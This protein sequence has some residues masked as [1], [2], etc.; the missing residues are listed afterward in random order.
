MRILMIGFL[1]A[2]CGGDKGDSGGAADVATPPNVEGR[3]NVQMSAAT[4]C[5]LES[6]WL[7][8]W[9]PGPLSIDGEPSSLTFNFGNG[10]EFGG[11]VDSNKNYSFSGEAEISLTL[12]EDTGSSEVM[13][14]LEV[15]HDGSFE[16]RGDC[17]EMDGNFEVR[18]DENND[19]LESNDCTI[20]SPIKATQ[21]EGGS[22]NGIL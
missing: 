1:L 4:G 7:E 11:A 20:T 13:A 17:W 15:L 19:G 9:V 10:M 16:K 6:Y 18:V 8:E 21:L 3:Y 12:N 5:E 2:G 22:C 14:R